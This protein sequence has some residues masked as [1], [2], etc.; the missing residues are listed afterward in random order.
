[1]ACRLLRE[2]DFAVGDWDSLK[3]RALLKRIP[4][5]TLQRGKDRSDLFYALAAA[6]ARGASEIVGVGLSG[7]RMDHQ[8]GVLADFAEASTWKGV[9]IRS[10]RLL[11]PDGEM[12]FVG[13]ATPR[14]NATGLQ[15]RTI[16]IFAWGGNAAGVTLTGL[17]YPLRGATL[18]PSSLGLSNV[19]VKSRVSVSLQAGRLV[20]VLPSRAR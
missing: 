6:V 5:L 15:G 14:W 12:T 4:H 20:V 16:S 10:L 8:L 7:G 1:M 17:R 9:G 18:K 11:D 13:P 19:A 3:R 2:P